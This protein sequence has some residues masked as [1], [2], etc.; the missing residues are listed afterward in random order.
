MCIFAII[1]SHSVGCSM[2][3]N[4]FTGTSVHA[5]GYTRHMIVLLSSIAIEQFHSSNTS[6]ERFRGDLDIFSFLI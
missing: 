4:S 3:L 6:K 2:V 5:K 1:I